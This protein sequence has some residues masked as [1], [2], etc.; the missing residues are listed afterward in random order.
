M[1]S[2][3]ALTVTL[4][5]AAQAGATNVP[6]YGTSGVDTIV[7]GRYGEYH[8]SVIACVNGNWQYSPGVVQPADTVSVWANAG[9]DSITIQRSL[10]TYVCGTDVK[11]LYPMT[12][13]DGCPN[14]Y[15]YG[16]AGND[17]IFGGACVEHF[18]G[19]TGLD[20][21]YG[22]A[23]NDYLYGGDDTDCIDD[24]TVQTLSCGSG[25]DYFTDDGTW[26]D[27][28]TRQFVCFLPG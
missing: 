2:F 3:I 9:A 22:G 21:L 16:G 20:T 14:I 19:D 15:V 4:V 6:F 26:S 11:L 10:G 28:E 27:C 7:V 24:A 25:T 8:E 5:I 12:S 23:G 13:G 17:A 18:Y 1:K